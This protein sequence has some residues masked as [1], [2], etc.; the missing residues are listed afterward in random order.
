LP[1]VGKKKKKKMRQK[2]VRPER[3]DD[4][5][6]AARYGKLPLQYR[7]ALRRSVLGEL[8]KAFPNQEGFTRDSLLFVTHLLADS[9]PF[10]R[11]CELFACE[12]G[13]PADHVARQASKLPPTL[14]HAQAMAGQLIHAAVLMGHGLRR[15]SR[16]QVVSIAVKWLTDV[17]RFPLFSA[18]QGIVAE[19][20]L[21][22]WVRHLSAV[23]ARALTHQW[24]ALLGHQFPWVREAKALPKTL[25]RRQVVQKWLTYAIP[26]I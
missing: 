20:D 19:S 1:L 15:R 22:Q 5:R 10:Q 13:A 6:F 7:L 23:K 24:S 2:Q 21:R 16:V 18:D 17:A 25:G 14:P 12:P 26:D 9:V 11:F 8:A 4:A 3:N